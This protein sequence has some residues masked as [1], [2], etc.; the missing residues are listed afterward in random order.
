[1]TPHP[2]T[3][4]FLLRATLRLRRSWTR[5]SLTRMVRREARLT[6]RLAL[7][8][9]QTDSLLLAAKEHRQRTLQLGHRLREMEES[10]RFRETGLPPQEGWLLPQG[11]T[12][13]PLEPEPGLTQP[14]SLD[15]RQPLLLGPTPPLSLEQMNDLLSGQPMRPTTSDDSAS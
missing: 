1:M 11:V 3:S 8:H 13:T 15:P 10:Q 14:L 2:S 12:L 6:R 7:L 9:R 4:S 5:W